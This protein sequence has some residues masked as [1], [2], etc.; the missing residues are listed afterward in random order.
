MTYREPDEAHSPALAKL[1][2]EA[3]RDVPA[4]T[5]LLPEIE[6]KRRIALAVDASAGSIG[7]IMLAVF[8][9][10]VAILTLIGAGSLD[11]DRNHALLV[12]G[13]TLFAVGAVVAAV[14]DSRREAAKEQRAIE[15]ELGWASQQPFPVTGYRDWLASDRSLLVVHL[16]RAVDETTFRN[17]V[18][19]IDP[20]IESCALDDRRYEVVVP[21]RVVAATRY[22]D[23]KLLKTVW[24]KLVLPL[25]A[26]VG[27]DRVAMGGTIQDRV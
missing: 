18:R 23:V 20:A 21:S 10:I 16:R 6:V 1:A 17:A 12:G 3:S 15:A 24:D 11:L 9:V 2:A 13:V 8:S 5:A 4:Q 14:R 26:D 27:I 19:A 25:H 22:G 7:M